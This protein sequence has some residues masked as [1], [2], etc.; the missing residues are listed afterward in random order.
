MFEAADSNK[1]NTMKM[2][3]E[4]KK[5]VEYRDKINTRQFGT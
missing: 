4:K 2:K 1:K 5:I 3:I